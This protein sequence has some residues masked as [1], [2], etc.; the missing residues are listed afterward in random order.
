MKLLPPPCYSF[1]LILNHFVQFFEQTGSLRRDGLRDEIYIQTLLKQSA[2]TAC[3]T[4]SLTAINKPS[5]LS[6]TAAESQGNRASFP[7]PTGFQFG[8]VVNLIR[9]HSLEMYMMSPEV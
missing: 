1:F 6:K 9:S 4:S 2:K 7:S 5:R 8:D 3:R